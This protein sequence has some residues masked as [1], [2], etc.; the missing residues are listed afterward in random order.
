MPASG[1][2][3]LATEQVIDVATLAQVLQDDAL[4][5]ELLDFR[6]RNMLRDALAVISE[7]DAAEDAEFF[8]GE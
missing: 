2:L 7:R 3:A 8:F 4:A 6:S 5:A 1:R